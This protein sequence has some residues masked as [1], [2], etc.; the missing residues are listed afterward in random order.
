MNLEDLIPRVNLKSK[1]LD[2][3]YRTFKINYALKLNQ[4]LT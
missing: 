3:K 2:M 1:Y 4:K